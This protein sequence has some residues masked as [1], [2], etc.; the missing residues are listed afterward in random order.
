MTHVQS[1]SHPCTHAQIAGW[2]SGLRL[3]IMPVLPMH[4]MQWLNVGTVH[5]QCWKRLLRTW[6]TAFFLGLCTIHY[7]QFRKRF[8]ACNPAAVVLF[9]IYIL[10][11]PCQMAL[12][13]MLSLHMSYGSP[14]YNEASKLIWNLLFCCLSTLCPSHWSY[15]CCC[16]ARNQSGRENQN[17]SRPQIIVNLLVCLQ[18]HLTMS[19]GILQNHHSFGELTSFIYLIFAKV[20]TIQ[21]R[22]RGLYSRQIQ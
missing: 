16:S 10:F 22:Q 6:M 21:W 1:W 19:N 11:H 8:R 17:Q 20:T 5:T 3:C 15:M 13:L 4:L 14:K 7:V 2:Q 18:P 9:Y 12:L